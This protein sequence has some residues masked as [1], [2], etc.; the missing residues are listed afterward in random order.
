[1]PG[2]IVEETVFTRTALCALWVVIGILVKRNKPEGVK[3]AEYITASSAV[4]P[5]CEV[6]EVS[7]ARDLIA[8]LRLRIVL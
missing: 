2:S 3:I 5:S 8:D 7:R 6:S 4:M 1:M